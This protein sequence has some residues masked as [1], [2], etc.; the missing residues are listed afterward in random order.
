VVALLHAPEGFELSLPP[1]ARTQQRAAGATV[2]LCFAPTVAALG[3]EMPALKRYIEDGAR[4][5]VLWR[6]KSSRQSTDVSA[7]R[8][9]EMCKN[10]E[11]SA[12]KTCAVDDV[13]SAVAVAR[14]R[15]NTRK[16]LALR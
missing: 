8:I 7:V 14:S 2:I 12:Y 5:W 4:G 3:R 15:R 6:K 16:D 9:V 13:W 11:L 10:L 1:G